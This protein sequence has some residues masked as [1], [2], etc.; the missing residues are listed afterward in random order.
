[1]FKTILFSEHLRTITLKKKKI[2]STFE[3]NQVQN[4][5]FFR[6]FE[7]NQ[8]QNNIFFSEH[9]RTITFK[10]TFFSEHLRT[11][12]LTTN[13]IMFESPA[14]LQLMASSPHLVKTIKVTILV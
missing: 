10:T 8:V 12:M 14:R 3:D 2:F 11:I 9:L 4:N 7:D 5:T 13:R 6:T 1:M